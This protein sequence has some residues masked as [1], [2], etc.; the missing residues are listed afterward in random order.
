MGKLVK[1]PSIP[2][3]R[4]VVNDVIHTARFEGTDEEGRNIY[5]DNKLPIILFEGTVKLHGTNASVCM[6]KEGDLWAQ[7]KGNVITVEK[8]NAAFAFFVEK[9]KEYF[10]LILGDLFKT[11]PDA[12][13]FCVYGEWA[14]KGIQKGVGISEIEK[15]FFIFDIKFKRE[16]EEKFHWVKD[17]WGILKTMSDPDRNIYS[18]GEFPIFRIG[19]DFDNPKMV[20]NTMIEITE[21]VEKQCPV[22]KEFGHEGIGE[23]VVWTGWFGDNRFIFKVKGDKHANSKVKKLAPV[24][25]ALEAAKIEF[26]NYATPAWRLEQMYAE[27][28]DTLNGGKGD[29]KRTGDFLRA[30]VNDVMKEEMYKMREMNLEPKQVNSLISKIA[31]G[32]FMEQLDKETGL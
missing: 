31:R 3:F 17:K 12:E 13:L 20:Q 11:N 23:G 29:I 25:E 14:G 18:I 15:S 30:V 10:E 21:E 27:T 28:F 7:S 4:N 26:A 2:Q 32:W 6:N 24:D 5:N 16:N 1:M 8:D 9:N 22:A 19:I